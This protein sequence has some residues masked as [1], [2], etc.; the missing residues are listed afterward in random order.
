MCARSISLITTLN[1]IIRADERQLEFPPDDNWNSRFTAG[2]LLVKI[3]PKEA[4]LDG[5]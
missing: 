1:G 2:G 5:D 4:I 3:A